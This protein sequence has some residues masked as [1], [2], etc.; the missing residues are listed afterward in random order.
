MNTKKIINLFYEEPDTDRW[1]KFDRYPRKIIRRLFRGKPKPGGVMLIVLQLMKGLDKLGI[2]YRFNDYKYAKNNPNELIGVIGKPHLIFE[3]KFQ[4]PILFGAGVFSHP[5]ECP[6]LFT[7]YPNVKKMLVPG[8]WMEKMCTPYYGAKV[9]A[10]PVGIDTEVWN[11]K[12]KDKELTVDFLIYDKI[13]WEHEKY[14]QTLLKPIIKELHKSKLTYEVIKY[15]QYEHVDLMSKLSRCKA[16]I[17]LC[18]HETQGQAYQQ[19]LATNTPILAWD[20]GG[21][22]KDPTFYPAIKFEPVS[23][24]PYWDKRC[25]LKFKN[26]TDFNSVLIEFIKNLNSNIFFSRNFILE[27]LTLEICAKKYAEIYYNLLDEN[28]SDS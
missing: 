2:P 6:N 22:W 25:G 14:E 18:E 23:S 11:D 20:R 10:W 5:I 27:N 24:V 8:K 28:S 26:D 17:F 19:I 9:L 1:F 16:V 4:N 13:R 12:L 3:E 21:F 7:Q 15:G